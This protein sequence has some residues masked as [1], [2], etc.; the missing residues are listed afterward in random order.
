MN[1]GSL[2]DARSMSF[3]YVFI[4]VVVIVLAVAAIAAVFIYRFIART[5]TKEWLEAQKNRET[6]LKDVDY[7]AKEANLTQSEKIRLWHICRRYKAKNIRYLYRSVNELNDMFREEYIRMT[8]KQTRNDE[9]IGIFFSLRFKLENAHNRKLTASSTRGIKAEQKITF[10]DKNNSPWQIK[11]VKVIDSGFYIE[12]PELANAEGKR[13]NPLEK[14][15]ITF[16]FPSG[17]AFNAITRAV[18]YEKFP[19]SNKEF[20]LLSNS[21]QIKPVVRRGA[22]RMNVDE[23]VSFAAIKNIGTKEKPVLEVQQKRYPGTMKDISASG[24]K[25]FCA[26]P[27]T[28]GQMV[29]IQFKIPGKLTDYEAQGKIVATKVM[30]DKKTFVLHIQYINIEQFVKNDIYSV[31]YGYS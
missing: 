21:T 4:A 13:P 7:V 26:L 19:D 10:Y 2:L 25:I 15:K 23:D 17:Q 16:T 9:K 8:T 3:L 29:D 6:K 31:I 27:I 18:R 5:H 20:L 14:V 30:P 12:L 1:T 24:C 11:V 28:K 22:K